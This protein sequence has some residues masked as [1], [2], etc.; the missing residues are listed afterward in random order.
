[1]SDAK[2]ARD[3]LLDGVDRLK[4]ARDPRKGNWV[5][6]N[7]ETDRVMQWYLDVENFLKATEQAIE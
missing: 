6:E 5:Q 2:Q 3:L 7:E 1:M 4:R